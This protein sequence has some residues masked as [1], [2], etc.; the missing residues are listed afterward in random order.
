MKPAHI[1]PLCLIGALLWALMLLPAT[2][3]S[4]AIDIEKY[5]TSMAVGMEPLEEHPVNLEL[6]YMQWQSLDNNRLKVRVKVTNESSNKTVKAFELYVYAE[7]VWGE[8][9]YGDTTVYPGTTEKKI[10][11]GETVYSDYI[12]IPE[13]RSIS[14]IYCRISRIAYIDGTVREYS[15]DEK[16]Y[17]GYE[18]TK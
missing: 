18:Y 14:T 3:A 16:E 9:L 15:S 8:R 6:G 13:R 4:A 5:Q 12:V 17:V 11:P 2:Q 10:K 7:D 1:R